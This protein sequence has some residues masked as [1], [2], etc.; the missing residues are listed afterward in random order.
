MNLTLTFPVLF[1]A[2]ENK[3]KRD[4]F[5]ASRKTYD[6]PEY[7]INEAE[8]AFRN[9]RIRRSKPLGKDN[10]D[11]I[12]LNGKLYRQ[13]DEAEAAVAY[14]FEEPFHNG[15][16]MAYADQGL[17]VHF[18]GKLAL[19]QIL[20]IRS[21]KVWPN[22]IGREDC[23]YDFTFEQSLSALTE[24]NTEEVAESFNSIAKAVEGL[25]IVDGVIWCETPPPK[26]FIALSEL[27]ISPHY[28]V[29]D[30]STLRDNFPNPHYMVIGRNFCINDDDAAEEY[31]DEL[32][33][34]PK[35]WRRPIED[36]TYDGYRAFIAEQPFDGVSEQIIRMSRG[37][38]Y[39]SVV[40]AHRK[41]I[42]REQL[43][44]SQ[45]AL[46]EEAKLA[47]LSENHLLDR[48]FDMSDNVR[49]LL[50]IWR[51]LGR[52]KSEECLGW[53]KSKLM[54]E[55]IEQTLDSYSCEPIRVLTKP[56]NL[57]LIPAK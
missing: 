40:E 26:R 14:L 38:A 36:E 29:F 5:I 6:I 51:T 28:T 21:K 50:E 39:A 24:I 19:Q 9:K 4:V 30:Y 7:S 34:F 47:L 49:E 56:N 35:H 13:L 20:G 54:D 16:N 1:S 45:I 2:Q 52:P 22:T 57:D 27:E 23:L 31:I 41:P 25:V 37:L 15:S 43:E 33:D 18:E 53:K 55:F 3:K 10:E 8:L 11:I 12:L 48:R 46:L 17:G 44:Y 42:L 32:K